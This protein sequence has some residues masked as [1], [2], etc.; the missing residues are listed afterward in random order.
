M[1]QAGATGST[2]ATGATGTTGATGSTGAAGPAI[3]LAVD[4]GGF[5]FTNGVAN[6]AAQTSPAPPLCRVLAARSTGRLL[7]TSRPGLAPA[8]RSR[9]LIW[10]PTSLSS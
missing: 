3:V 6:P 2:G 7:P 10:G 9:L 5:A 8:S 4:K 1:A